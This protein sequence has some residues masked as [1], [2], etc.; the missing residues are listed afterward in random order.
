VAEVKVDDVVDLWRAGVVMLPTVAVQYA[1]VASELHATELSE[2]GAFSRPGGGMGPFHPVWTALRNTMQDKVAVE[3]RDN[4]VKAG[5][6]LKKIAESYA[7]TDHMSAQ[8][9]GIFQ[10]RT[11][12]VMDTSDNPNPAEVP[13]PY[14]PEAPST[15]DP[16]PEDAPDRPGGI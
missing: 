4:L 10:E 7:T 5:E 15:D 2:S 14:V 11:E 1:T 9:L 8:Q 12:D 13:P 16:H 6:A 3:S